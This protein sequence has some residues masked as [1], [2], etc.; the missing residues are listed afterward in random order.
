VPL[1][2]GGHLGPAATWDGGHQL[3]SEPPCEPREN[4]VVALPDVRYH[5]SDRP[6]SVP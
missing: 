6:P 5:P 3:P 2:T 1:G 4:R